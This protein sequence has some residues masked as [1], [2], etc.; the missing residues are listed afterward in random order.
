[1]KRFLYV[2]I[3]V[4]LASC[5]PSLPIRQSAKVNVECI[6]KFKP[7][8]KSDLYNASVDVV[9]N[10]IGGLVLFK[11]MTDGSKRVVFTNET[12]VK[13]F[14]FGFETNGS[15]ITHQII[16]KLNKKIV[17]RTLQNDFGLVLMIKVGKET[18]LAFSE[19]ENLKFIFGIGKNAD[20]IVTNVDC[21][22][23]TRIEKG[24]D[25]PQ[26][27]AQLFSD[28]IHVPDSIFIEHLN[29]NMKITLRH[30]VR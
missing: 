30:L 8:F 6:K 9:G 21:S 2:S 16:K 28:G 22:Q 11:T 10:H 12:G 1:M 5:A 24:A 7:N 27:I 26:T 13:F 14:D 18:P 19:G 20:C 25:K 4:L 15:V 29:F 17:V 23:L 3:S